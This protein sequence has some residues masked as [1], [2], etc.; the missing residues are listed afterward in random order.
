QVN[1]PG[2]DCPGAAVS[3]STTTDVSGSYAFGVNTLL[4][5]PLPGTVYTITEVQPAFLLNGIDRNS[6]NS[7]LVTNTNPLDN[8]FTVTYAITEQSTTIAGLTFGERSI[9]GGSLTTASDCINDY[10]S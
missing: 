10:M 6:L 1:L 8:L 9:D 5:P 7:P 2:H 3:L 4:K